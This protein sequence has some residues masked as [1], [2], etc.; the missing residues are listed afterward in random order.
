[1]VY[2]RR[3][4]TPQRGESIESNTGRI[5]PRRVSVV[6]VSEQTVQ[7]VLF[8]KQMGGADFFY[9]VSTEKMEAKGRETSENI[10][11]ACS[12]EDYPSETVTVLEDSLVDIQTKLNERVRLEDDD[13]ISVN[14]T[15]GTKIMSLGVYNF[16]A[17]RGGADIYYIPIGKNAL[18]KIFPFRRVMTGELSARLSLREYMTAS[19]VGFNEKLYERKNRLSKPAEVCQSIM[20]V[21]LD[22][23]RRREFVKVSERIRT[24]FRGK[25]V[26]RGASGEESLLVEEC[27]TRA[28]LGMVFEDPE[29]VTA[30]ETRYVTGDWFEEYVYTAIQSALGLPEDHI[31]MGLVLNKGIN[32]EYDVI[33]TRENALYV[34]EC[35]TDVSDSA[36]DQ[37]AR[38][39]ALFTSTL[40]KA[41]TLKKE[42]GLWVKYYLFAINDFSR[43]T[44][45]QKKRAKQLDIKLVGTE[46]LG[47][48]SRLEAF[49]RDM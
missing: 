45:D 31:G 43:L 34:I 23:D 21:Y 35:K 27:M 16:F 22:P 7:N 38:I 46:T 15:G 32:N 19:G 3:E 48:R 36:S 37:E 44:D 2:M 18:I 12:I 33:F 42:F 10:R 28:G 47:D 14:I 20:D 4:W 41:A 8:I 30:Q 39:S 29:R 11:K 1:M 24:S 40:Y 6:I 9:F 5:M 25:P 26:R 13:I 49:I 17:N